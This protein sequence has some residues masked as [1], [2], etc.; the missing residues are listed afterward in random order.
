MERDAACST[1]GRPPIGWE[2]AGGRKRRLMPG[3]LFFIF[4]ALL[5]LIGV[6]ALLLLLPDTE[7]TGGGT[8]AAGQTGVPAMQ[9][10]PVATPAV[11]KPPA[12]VLRTLPATEPKLIL[13]GLPATPPAGEFRPSP[14]GNE[15]S[16]IKVGEVKVNLNVICRRT[17]RSMRVCSCE[18]CRKERAQFGL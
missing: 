16:K 2:S 18:R 8:E 11:N 5:L 10:S 15:A 4:V 17:G 1:E 12:I 9:P 7:T 3:W 13:R 6:V 14:S